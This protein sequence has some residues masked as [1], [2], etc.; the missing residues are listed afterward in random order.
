[1]AEPFGI[2]AVV[3]GKYEI[4]RVLG[5]GGVGIVVEARHLG[6]DQA[7]AIKI[8]RPAMAEGEAA[9]R[10]LREA[11]A[12]VRLKSEHVARVTDVGTSAE[13]P[14]M[15]MELLQGRDLADTIDER[16]RL[17]V[18]EA[19][20]LVLQAIEGIAEAHAAGIIH[21]DIKPANL[22]VTRRPD[23][24]PLVKVLDFG[25]SKVFGMDDGTQTSTQAVMGSPL[26]MA[27]EQMRAT[28]D[29]DGRADVWSLGV[30]LYQ[31]VVGQLP[32]DDD[33]FARLALLVHNEVA[34]RISTTLPDVSPLFDDIV[35]SC[36]E[37]E[38]SARF[39]SVASL[40]TALLPLASPSAQ[41]H[42]D[43]AVRMLGSAG[44]EPRL[45]SLSPPAM[46]A[47]LRPPHASPGTEM[48]L[49]TSGSRPSSGNKSLV[50]L[51]GAFGLLVAALVVFFAA[52]RRREP[53]LAPATALVP[54]SPVAA[55]TSVAAPSPSAMP[56]ASAGS[57]NVPQLTLAT[58]EAS[59][60]PPPPKGRAK[61][62]VKGTG[63]AADPF[64][65]SRK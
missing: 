24:T 47:S 42:V 12:S 6:L 49:S 36:L 34:P 45:P 33:N 15:V 3:D 54:S 18:Q 16:G 30:T 39:P 60:A 5:E 17:P 50:V 38:P 53:P 9:A 40:A 25:I 65:D 35:A 10:F 26:F 28:K 52:S 21:R 2:G 63:P 57:P 27:P 64:G 29:V 59:G 13:A 32:F 55:G 23:G 46:S 44:P 22:F 48:A 51:A 4:V 37:R 41:R 8:L 61:G 7:V 1:M 62:A 58:A 14:Y 20:D 19:V 11:R 43:A 56:D 31:C